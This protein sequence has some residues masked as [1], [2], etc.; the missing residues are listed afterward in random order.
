MGLLESGFCVAQMLLQRHLDLFA[1][2]CMRTASVQMRW[3]EKAS[4]RRRNNFKC[5]LWFPWALDE[6]ALPLCA[7]CSPQ[8]G[9]GRRSCWLRAGFAHADGF[10]PVLPDATT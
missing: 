5:P 3:R 6:A 8:L 10:A 2:F 1:V 7:I 4:G 9:L